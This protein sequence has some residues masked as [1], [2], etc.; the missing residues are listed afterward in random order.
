M[1]SDTRRAATRSINDVFRVLSIA[2]SAVENVD[3]D[4]CFSNRF[5]ITGVDFFPSIWNK[6]AFSKQN[7]HAN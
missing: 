7:D 4:T 2:G 6:V 3:C 5:K 1:E